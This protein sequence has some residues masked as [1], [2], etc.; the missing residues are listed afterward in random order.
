MEIPIAAFADVVFGDG[1]PVSFGA[2]VGFQYT[3]AL[4][5]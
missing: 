1:I 3:F 2:T 5:R 4:G